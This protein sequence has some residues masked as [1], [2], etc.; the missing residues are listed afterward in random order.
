MESALYLCNRSNARP[1][2]TPSDAHAGRSQPAEIIP[3]SPR[4]EP[5][6]ATAWGDTPHT[7]RHAHTRRAPAH[8]PSRG[9]R[10]PRAARAESKEL[11][12]P[13]APTPPTPTRKRL[14]PTTRGPNQN[15]PP[16]NHR[17]NHPTA[18]HPPDL[19]PPPNPLPSM[20][21]A[22]KALCSRSARPAAHCAF[23]DRAASGEGA[24]Q[25]V[26]GRLADSCCCCCCCF[27]RLADCCR[28]DFASAICSRSEG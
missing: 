14:P 3:G 2:T 7:A 12:A 23:G 13:R 22:S 11:H 10:P 21:C 1:L 8:H 19:P 26:F 4:F 27:C 24:V 16:A 6:A 17:P 20:H 15:H 9:T 28:I 18:T 25:P 5:P